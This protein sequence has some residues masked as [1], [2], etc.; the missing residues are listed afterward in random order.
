MKFFIAIFALIIIFSSVVAP[1]FA[2]EKNAIDAAVNSID[3]G[4]GGEIITANGSDPDVTVHNLVGNAIK[5]FLGIMGTVALCIFIYSGI[6]W[7]TA[8]GTE[9]RITTAQNSMIW[10][11]LGLFA[12]FASYM[13][14]KFVI[15]S[16]A[17]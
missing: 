4:F 6:I 12:V 15:T 1:V 11:A 2:S 13:I 16:L 10:A 5:V 17:F 14:I 9:A 8:G 3:A 7:M